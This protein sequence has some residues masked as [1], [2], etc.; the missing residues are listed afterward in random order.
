MKL[1]LRP[2]E[3]RRAA[4]IRAG[5]TDLDRFRRSGGKDGG[6]AVLKVMPA[7]RRAR[8]FLHLESIWR[9]IRVRVKEVGDPFTRSLPMEVHI[10]EAG[11]EN[12]ARIWEE[13]RGW[14]ESV[15]DV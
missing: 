7:T 8:E 6:L 12:N 5:W 11:W 14:W 2:E 9:H 15:A 1:A 13:E 4:E 10:W 3:E